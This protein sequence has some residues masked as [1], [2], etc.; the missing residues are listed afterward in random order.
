MRFAINHITAPKLSL[1]DFFAAA[2]NLGLTEV[3][4]R[5]DLPDIVNT[6]PAAEVKA[7]AQK[8]G[9]DI[10]SINALYPFNVWSG[11]LPKKA[12]ALADYAAASGAKALVMC[13]LNDGTEVS[14]DDLAVALIAMKPI[15]QERGLIGLVEPL[16]FPISS[17]RTKKE[18]LRAIDAADGGDVY[19]LM[20]DTFHHH[21]AGETEFFPDRTG[22]VHI[23]GVVDPDVYVNDMLDAHRVL[24]DSKDRLENIAQIKAMN[25]GGYQGPYSFEPFADEVH[26]L[27]DP[28]VSVRESMDYVS[29]R[30]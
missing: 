4:I 18:A 11:D 28:E 29:S 10:I 30:L 23:S 21:L 1:V 5:N 19:K 6:I 20:H 9:V 14:F 2:R 15:L 13:P 12:V 26:E 16:G 17:L 7:A 27:S 22:L 24:V 8:A 3:E 25:A